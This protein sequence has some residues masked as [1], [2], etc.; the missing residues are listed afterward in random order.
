MTTPTDHKKSRG[1]GDAAAQVGDNR[2][3][4]D[5]DGNKAIGNPKSPGVTQPD[6]TESHEL[7]KRSK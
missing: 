1:E 6:Q 2:R 3:A 4:G 5:T 7:P